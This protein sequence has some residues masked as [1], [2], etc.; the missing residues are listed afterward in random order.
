MRKAAGL[1]ERLRYEFD[2]SMAAG[3][4]ALVGWLALISVVVKQDGTLLWVLYL[5]QP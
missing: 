1:K 2:K 5:L 3:A 4:V